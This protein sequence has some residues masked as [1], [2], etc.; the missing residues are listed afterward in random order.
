MQM[1]TSVA[2]MS[3]W[4]GNGGGPVIL[5]PTM[6]A[7]HS[8]HVALI[9]RAREL[10]GNEGS[11]IVSIF[12]NPTQFGPNEDLNNYPRPIER[13]LEKCQPAGANIIFL[14]EAA[15]MYAP[16][17]SMTVLETSLS[18]RLCGASRPGHFEGVCIVVLKLFNIVR[19]DI[20]VFGK[21]DYQ[22]LAIIR[23]MVRD[24]NFPMEITGVETVRSADGLA[25]SSR[26]TYLSEAERAQAP[27]IRATLLEAAAAIQEGQKNTASLRQH[28]ISALRRNVTLGTVDYV[29]I[30]DRESLQRIS[31]IDRPALIAVA[32]FFG[33]TRLIDN[34]EV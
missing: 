4:K 3:A 13:D 11:V 17:R 28:M 10:A 8:G 30:V 5:V 7:L 20:A 25:K 21:K 34:I 32:I 1:I 23:R 15:D 26:N 24:L 27:F 33:T 2:E 29:E 18:K 14:P 22:Q 19:P 12:V 6:G 16:D 9:E 31:T